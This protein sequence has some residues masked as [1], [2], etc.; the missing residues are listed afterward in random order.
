ME[1]RD[2]AILIIQELGGLALAIDQA[3]T[4]INVRKVPLDS[5]S[6]VYK[7]RRDAILKHVSCRC[8]KFPS[9]TSETSYVSILA[10]ETISD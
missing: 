9:T 3:A 6:G 2:H 10:F 4:Y 7:K 5:F 1:N 8:T